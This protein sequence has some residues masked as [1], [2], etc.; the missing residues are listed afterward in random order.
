MFHA[1]FS[2]ELLPFLWTNE[3]N[4]TLNVS[5]FCTLYAQT[6]VFSF[7]PESSKC[8]RQIALKSYFHV[9]SNNFWWVL[10]FIR[11]M[12]GDSLCTRMRRGSNKLK[13]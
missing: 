6:S 7:Q 12:Y 5:Y 4:K 3:A 13:A 9:S 1:S 8:I 2:N 11:K 10:Y